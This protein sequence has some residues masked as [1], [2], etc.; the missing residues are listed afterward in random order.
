MKLL[1]PLSTKERQL[2]F[3]QTSK[4]PGLIE[5]LLRGLSPGQLTTPQVHGFSLH[6]QVW[7]LADLEREGFQFRLQALLSQK[8]P[9]LEN[10]DGDEVAKQRHYHS[11]SLQQ[12]FMIFS[13][14]R[15]KN[16][17]LL[18]GINHAD[19]MRRGMQNG[20]GEVCVADVFRAMAA[21]DLSHIQEIEAILRGDAPLKSD[22]TV[23][24]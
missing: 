7:H 23:A 5:N 11:L 12:A 20:V 15:L 2:L 16:L 13:E 9:C 8:F 1:A 18:S 19:W 22:S 3:K 10:F 4:T 17:W 24:A 6:E 21:H 14:T